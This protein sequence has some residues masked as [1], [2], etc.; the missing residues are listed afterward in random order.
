LDA[1]REACG[2][3]GD[4]RRTGRQLLKRGLVLW[5]LSKKREAGVAADDDP[6]TLDA[7]GE[8][9][10]T[11]AA[12]MAMLDGIVRRGSHLVR[13]GRWLQILANATLCWETPDQKDSAERTLHIQHGRIRHTPEGAVKKGL[14]APFPARPSR[15][16]CRQIFTGATTYDR[17]R[18]L[19]TELR[20]LAGEKRRVQILPSVG[21]PIANRGLV[22]LLNLI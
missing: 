4:L 17:L 20:R 18:V 2:Y 12:V 15:R 13:R 3:R 6:V 14:R 21:G 7:G 10:W 1:Y 19:T 8:K 22:R 9:E 11:A 5:R 16:A